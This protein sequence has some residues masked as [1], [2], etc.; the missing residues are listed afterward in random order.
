MPTITHLQSPEPPWATLLVLKEEQTYDNLGRP[1][2]GFVMR[3]LQGRKCRTKSA[4]FSEFAR[5]LEFPSY[6]GKNW[7]AF[8][9]CL[10]DLEW[11]PAA[12]YLLIITDAEQVLNDDDQEDYKTFINILQETGKVWGTEHA[13][14]PETPFHAVL[15]VAERNKAKRKT[16][17]VP[18]L[19]KP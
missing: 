19:K 13:G 2:S 17:G 15:A 4:L 10:T 14:R 7:D 12:G 6:F 3:V 5:V 1:P 16:W 18:I 8:E 11:L 9:E